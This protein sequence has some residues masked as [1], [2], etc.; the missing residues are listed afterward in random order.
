MGNE[1]KQIIVFSIMPLFAG[2]ETLDFSEDTIQNVESGSYSGIFVF[3]QKNNVSQG[4]V[5][6]TFTDN[7]YTCVPEIEFLPP[8]GGGKYDL[9]GEKIILTDLSP[10]RA[11]FD[12]SLILNGEFLFTRKDKSIILFQKDKKR[13]RQRYVKLTKSTAD[14]LFSEI[15]QGLE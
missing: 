1:M 2:C 12:W 9:I 11:H 4:K 3:T 14:S 7:S 13:E 6:F 8:I 15:M 10:H 5:K